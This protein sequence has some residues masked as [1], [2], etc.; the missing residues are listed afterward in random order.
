MKTSIVIRARNDMPVIKRT[1][2]GLQRQNTAFEVF[3]FD[4]GST[5]GTR[6]ELARI[7]T[8]LIDVEKYIPG[9]VLNQGM[10][11]SKSEKVVFL[12]SDCVPM[13]EQWLG[14]LLSGFTDANCAAVFGRQIP[15]KDCQ[16]IFY[17]DT[18]DTF[19]D[20]ER[21]KYWKHCFSMASS[22]VSRKVWQ[23]HPFRED[24]QY[25]EDIDW[26]W[27]MRQHGFSIKY[28][29][30]SV[31]EHSHNY[32]PAQFY[33]RQYGE[34]KAEAAI[35]TWTAW[36]KNWLRYSL[37]PLFRQIFSDVKYAF[38]FHRPKIIFE[39]PVYRISQMLGRRC[40]FIDG[41]KKLETR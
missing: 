8:R 12:N 37:M 7:A 31:V 39:S 22:A 27:R 14:N 1:I 19:G 25:S 5:D 17:K 6:E 18:E 23:Q 36:E 3:A 41:L 29:A 13:H 4:N 26:T 28:V 16:A 21:Q 9:Q 34:G 11:I 40:G 35:F 15:R 2:A 38:K 20:G 32:T 33:R 30:D 10:E 24:I